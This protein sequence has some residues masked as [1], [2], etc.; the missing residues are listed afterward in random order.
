LAVGRRGAKVSFKVSKGSKKNKFGGEK[1]EKV[2]S[3]I[4]VVGFKHVSVHV[5]CT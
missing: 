2:L 4:F 3:G 5:L 1:N